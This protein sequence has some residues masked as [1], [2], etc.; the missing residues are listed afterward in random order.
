MTPEFQETWASFVSEFEARNRWLLEDLNSSWSDLQATVPAK[1]EGFGG[2]GEIEVPASLQ[3]LFDSA[4]QRVLVDPVGSLQKLRPLQRALTAFEAY[5]SRMEDL[6]RKLPATL[7]I[8]SREFAAALRP[9][10]KSKWGIHWGFGG[11]PRPIP[12]RGLAQT[13]LQNWL[14]ERSKLDGALLLRF[15]QRTLAILTP[16]QV[17]SYEA[18][19]RAAALSP[20]TKSL[21]EA[22]RDWNARIE[23]NR[24]E[25][26]G[27]PA[28]FAAQPASSA[29][30]LVPSH[31][32]RKDPGVVPGWGDSVGA[33]REVL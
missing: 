7:V 31:P 26:H 2:E 9:H 20:P 32:T 18:L 21:E 17:I 23:R 30:P 8:S 15:A 3:E 33:A 24:P 6:G 16:W 27:T 12:V 22:R 28:E 1:G 11:K 5:D 29:C 4:A 10:S 19:R 25:R 14:V 13:H